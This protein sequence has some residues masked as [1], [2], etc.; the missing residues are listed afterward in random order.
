LLLVALLAGS[1]ARAQDP[2]RPPEMN[3]ALLEIEAPPASKV[4]IDGV[5]QGTRRQVR[6][7]PF[8][9]DALYS[10]QVRLELKDGKTIDRTVLLRSGWHVRLPVQVRDSSLPALALQTGHAQSLWSVGLSAD[11]RRAVTGGFDGIVI[12]W[13]AETGKQLQTFKG[14]EISLSADGRRLATKRFDDSVM[15]WET[16]TG[17]QLHSF[18]GATSFVLS[19]DGRRLALGEKKETIRLLDAETGKQLRAFKGSSFA[20]SDDGRRLV[21]GPEEN[22]AILWDTETGK[23]LHT[24]EMPSERMVS[25]AFSGDGRRLATGL[26]NGSVLLWDTETGKQLRE[27]KVNSNIRALSADGRRLVTAE[28]GEI[29]LWDTETGKQLHRFKGET[30]A[31]NADGRRLMT[32]GS[33][34][35][36]AV[37]WDTTTGNEIRAFQ[38]HAAGNP[39]VALSADGRRFVTA[40]PEDLPVLWDTTTGSAHP[41]NRKPPDEMYSL[42]LSADGRRLAAGLRDGSAAL[43]DGDTGKYLRTFKGVNKEQNQAIWSLSLSADGRRLATVSADRDVILWDTERGNRL[44]TF[45][46]ARVALSGDGRWLATG[47]QSIELWNTETGKQRDGFKRDTGVHFSL[48][49]DSTCRRLAVGSSDRTVSLWD[50]ETAKQL[51]T[52]KASAGPF[53]LS[54]VSNLALPIALGAEGRYILTSARGD[55]AV[56]WDADTGRELQNFSGH[57]GPVSSLGLTADGRRVL[58]GTSYGP[59][60]LWDVATGDHL[61][62]LISIEGGKDWL[63]VTSEGLFDGS[64]GGRQKVAFRIGEGLNIVP[65]D[66]FFQDYYRPGLLASLYKGE[67]PMPETRLAQKQ[68]P[69]VRIVSPRQGG[70]VEAPRT[71]L[72]VEALDQGG[73]VQGPWLLHNGARVLAGGQAE[74]D[75]KITRRRFTV[76]LVQGEN[77]FEVKA[78]SSDG[79]WES[80]PATL[81]LRY[82]KAL[83]KPVLHLVALGINRYKQSALDLKFAAN[84]ARAMCAVFERRGKAFYAEVKPYP[85]LDDQATRA[86]LR[87]ALHKVAREAKPQDTLILFIAGHGTMVGQRYYFIP[88]EFQR[89]DGRSLEDD[90]RAQGLPGDELADDVGAV[91][92][93]KRLLIFDTCHSGG[94]VGLARTTRNPFAFRGAIERLSRSQGVFTIA[95]TASSDEAQEVKELGHGVLTYAL[96]AG[97]RA[98]DKGPL[99]EEGIK[100]SNPE[101]TTDVLEWFS[102]AAGRVPRLTEKYF[103][104]EQDVQTSGQGASFPILPVK[105]R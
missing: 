70:V 50:V 69:W 32:T 89:S 63:V 41:A 42:A 8:R 76:A 74:R 86:N 4:R 62:R 100:P 39:F 20:L 66:R 104:K 83:D 17:K 92:A 28:L 75:G 44:H 96:L 77:R 88:H 34:G 51:Q 24:F 95:A 97:L 27:V 7:G 10:Y 52:F 48:T 91:P 54:S 46:G 101:Q 18:K 58:A 21:T 2:V 37:L 22:A 1:I 40:A 45:K 59:A 29:L 79:S 14:I 3:M 78:A 72:E 11:G 80:E 13:D 57:A 67:R 53:H 6:I 33:P 73:G 16:E 90:I 35:N 5:D 98:V 105:E 12:L 81:T 56:L 55:S 30:V 19:G 61:A 71:M 64:A 99:A 94:A 49:L 84:D 23:Q 68:A 102:F 43:W 47:D 65:V 25:F 93:L 103:G 26:L 36:T 87:A 85:L 15:L 9:D 38:G 60:T 31:L 82:E